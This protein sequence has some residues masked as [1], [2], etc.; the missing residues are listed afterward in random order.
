MFVKVFAT[1]F[2]VAIPTAEAFQDSRPIG[3]GAPIE[4]GVLLQSSSLRVRNFSDVSQVLIFES[5]GFKLSR[6]LPVGMEMDW[7]FTPHALDGV[8]MEVASLSGGSWRYTGTL[9]L[10]DYA[11]SGSDTMWVQP[12]VP[13]SLAWLQTASGFTL[14]AHGASYLPT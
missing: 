9:S 12:F 5:N 4:V 10:S 2:F 13:Q 6:S 14:F 3:F 1:V 7:S 8:N 11:V